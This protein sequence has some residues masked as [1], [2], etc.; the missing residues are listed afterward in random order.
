MFLN[1][2]PLTQLKYSQPLELILFHVIQTR[3]KYHKCSSYPHLLINYLFNYLIFTGHTTIVH[4][5]NEFCTCYPT[6]LYG[7][8]GNWQRTLEC[9]QNKT[10][11]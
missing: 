11:S 5:N 7:L 1:P 6:K 10:L 4:L 9:L 3:I 8:H 2:S